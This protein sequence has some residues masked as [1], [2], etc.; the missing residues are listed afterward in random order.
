MR[1]TSIIAML[2]IRHPEIINL[3]TGNLYPLTSIF[4]IHHPCESN[5]YSVSLS[6][7]FQIII[8]ITI[9]IRLSFDHVTYFHLH[10]AF[11]V[12]PCCC[13]LQDFLSS[14]DRLVFLPFQVS[15]SHIFFYLF[16]RMEYEMATQSS[17]LAG[18]FY[19]Q[20]ILAGSSSWGHKEFRA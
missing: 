7:V 15:Q 6:S 5:L 14:H 1:Y 8:S 20:G 10:N 16:I 2:Y 4:S 18:K 11:K 13:K 12:H 3:L 19:G 17:I 9:C